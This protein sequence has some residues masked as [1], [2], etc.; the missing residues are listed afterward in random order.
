MSLFVGWEVIIISPVREMMVFAWGVKIISEKHLGLCKPLKA[1][2][3]IHSET[4]GKNLFLK[5]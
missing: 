5:Q 4:Q 1:I 3:K 2:S